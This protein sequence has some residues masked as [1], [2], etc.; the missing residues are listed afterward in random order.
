MKGSVAMLPSTPD[1]TKNPRTKFCIINF[2]ICDPNPTYWKKKKEKEKAKTKQQ[3]KTK[4]ER[5]EI[6]NF[7]FINEIIIWSSSN[8]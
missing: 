3:I 4:Q 8:I 5:S 6:C 7:V 1:S 2:E